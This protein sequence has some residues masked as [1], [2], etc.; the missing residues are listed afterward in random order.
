MNSLKNWTI[1]ALKEIKHSYKFHKK[2]MIY[3]FLIYL[4][5]L[6]LQTILFYFLRKN[7]ASL[8]WI[9][10]TI[11]ISSMPTV[12][13]TEY[14]CK[15]I[16]YKNPVKIAFLTFVLLNSSLLFILN[17]EYALV[18]EFYNY[19][20]GLVLFIGSYLSFSDSCSCEK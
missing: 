19:I 11:I 18:P 10:L 15:I 14:S 1:K 7:E 12:L 13:F 16:G 9:I 2:E 6:I 4:F 3:A 20:L 17:L 5:C 8:V